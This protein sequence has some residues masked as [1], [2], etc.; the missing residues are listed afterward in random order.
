MLDDPALHEGRAALVITEGECDA[1][2]A[3]D[4]GYPFAVSVPDGAP[5][6]P[7]GKLMLETGEQL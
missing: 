1:L 2:T 4:C 7:A 6:V 5:P 3:I